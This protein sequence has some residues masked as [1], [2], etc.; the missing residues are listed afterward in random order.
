MLKTRRRAATRREHLTERRVAAL[1]IPAKRTI[2]YDLK[3]SELG[4]KLSPS[5]ARTFFW[6]RSVAGKPAWRTI[7]RWPDIDL[8]AAR[9]KAAKYNVTLAEWK[10][11]GSVGPNPFSRP[12]PSQQPTLDELVEDYVA[13]HVVLT[14][15]NPAK[16]AR[17]IR[18]TLVKYLPDWRDRRIGSLTRQD[19]FDLHRKL[20]VAHGR[21]TANRVATFVRT[22]LNWGVRAGLYRGENPAARLALFKESK[23]ERYLQPDELV[24]LKRALDDEP[25]AD[26]HDFVTLALATGARKSNI[27]ALAW[28]DVNWD[29]LTWTIRRAKNKKPHTVDL[30][31]AAVAVLEARFQHRDGDC[32]WVF[33]S[34]TSASGHATDFK[35]PWRALLKRAGIEN[36]CQHDLRRTFASYMAIAG[37]SLQQ[38]GAA[39]GHLSSSA[40]ATY[41]RLHREAVRNALAAGDRQMTAMMAAA[42]RKLPAAV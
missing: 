4:L 7:G 17:G 5:G 28:A 21:V 23:R 32:P 6:F 29:T 36:L 14:A 33:P 30:A 40:T 19:V 2:L 10:K 42:R 34:P 26:L 9:A 22:I 37:V 31:P 8:D 39:L 15:A 18:W 1:P 16:A 25:N 35:K 13:R 12:R 11:E 38:I 41:A 24:R 27:H 3:V 20:G